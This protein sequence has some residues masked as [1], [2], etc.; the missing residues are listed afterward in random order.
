MKHDLRITR[1]LKRAKE[2]QKQESGDFA[3]RFLAAHA[4]GEIICRD[5]QKLKIGAW[6][7]HLPA[8]LQND[9][10]EAQAS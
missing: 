9:I 6:V 10:A 2:R 7:N 1:L 5:G 3:A 8:D 4:L